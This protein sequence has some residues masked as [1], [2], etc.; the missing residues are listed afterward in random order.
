MY[1]TIYV[2]GAIDLLFLVLSFKQTTLN[3][4]Q[5][6]ILQFTL[7]LLFIC[8]LSEIINFIII[9]G[10]SINEMPGVFS[11]AHYIY[12]LCKAPLPL[13][14]LLY[15]AEV[16]GR[17]ENR[18]FFYYEFIPSF[19]MIVCLLIITNPVHHKFFYIKS[20]RFYNG[21]WINSLVI[22]SLFYLCIAVCIMI[23]FRKNLSAGKWRS[24]SAV[25]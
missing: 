13:M 9:T 15:T 8:T 5:H 4:R 24:Q 1:A 14:M 17:A 19:Y 23:K 10:E 18:R 25:R 7:L 16:L 3:K 6:R 21:T 20:G 2:A 12:I 11:V 22:L